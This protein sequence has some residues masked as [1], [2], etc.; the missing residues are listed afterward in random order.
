M[1]SVAGLAGQFANGI[2]LNNQSFLM[3][4]LA[5]VGGF[6]GSYYGSKKMSNQGVRYM[7][8]VVLIAAS[9]K[10]LFV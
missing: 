7:L 5:I 8:V 9:A 2:V 4:G 10:L 6:L 1:N 3:V